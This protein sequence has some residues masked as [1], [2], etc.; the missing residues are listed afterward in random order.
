MAKKPVQS[1]SDRSD[2]K[3]NKTLAVRIV[4]KKKP[5]A[6]A[7]EVVAIGKEGIRPL[8]QPEPGVHGQD[9]DQ[10]GVRWP[11]TTDRSVT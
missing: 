4:L 5:T 10:Y 9:E 3:K 2:P 6:K 7:A 8:R 11:A 1:K